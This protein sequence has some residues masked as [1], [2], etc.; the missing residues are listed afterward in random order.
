MCSMGG[1]AP[2]KLFFSIGIEKRTLTNHHR[3]RD[4]VFSIPYLDINQN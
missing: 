4:E 1:L 3:D 2:K